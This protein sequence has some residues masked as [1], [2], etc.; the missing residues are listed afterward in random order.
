MKKIDLHIHTTYSDGY[1]S[2]QDI[3]ILAKNKKLST[4]SITD[5]DTIDVYLKDNIIEKAKELELEIIPGVEISTEHNDSEIHILGYNFDIYNKK[6]NDVLNF[7]ITERVNRVKRIIKKLNSNGIDITF[8][9]LEKLHKSTTYGRPHVADMM[10]RKGYIKNIYEAF[11]YHIG[12]NCYAYEKKI[13]ISP[14]IAI[15]IIHEA[16]G[17]AIMAHPNKTN[18]EILN[19][20][21]N[22]GID[23][24]EIIHPSHTNSI[25]NNL[26]KL[27]DYYF[28]LETGGSDFHGGNKNDNENLG[29][30]FISETVYENLLKYQLK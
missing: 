18:E 7:I 22:S 6:L 11:T 13:H 12:I 28:L 25:K 9:E 23:G 3:L 21:I 14:K 1:Y 17:I 8:E 26:K 10:I 16:G 19:Y 27:V 5:H 15:D 24:F 29:N 2:P 20:L 4:I 30:Y